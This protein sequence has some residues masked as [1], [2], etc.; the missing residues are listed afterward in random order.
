MDLSQS[1]RRGIGSVFTILSKED[2]RVTVIVSLI[3]PLMFSLMLWRKIAY[4]DKIPAPT[5]PD[6]T[7]SVSVVDYSF[8]VVVAVVA[9]GWC[10]EPVLTLLTCR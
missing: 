7:P 4:R 8:V 2:A 5:F 10:F 6:W 1:T 3:P 9:A